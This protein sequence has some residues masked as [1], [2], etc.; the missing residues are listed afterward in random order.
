[1]NTRILFSLAPLLLLSQALLG[2]SFRT[3]FYARDYDTQEFSYATLDSASYYAEISETPD[4]TGWYPA[5]FYF[6]RRIADT[7]LLHGYGHFL[8]VRGKQ[9]QGPWTAY[10]DGT[11][12]VEEVGH[13]E[14]GK[15][16]GRWEFY[17]RRG[18]LA[19]VKHYQQGVLE[20]LFERYYY[21]A[22]GEG[23]LYDVGNYH[24]GQKQGEWR[25]YHPNGQQSAREVYEQDSLVSWEFWDPDG[26][27]RDSKSLAFREPQF[28][29]GDKALRAY[30]R[31]N[32]H[33]PRA[34]KRMGV[35]GRVYVAFTV[36]SDGTIGEVFFP[37][38]SIDILEDEAYR[39]IKSMPKWQPAI[40]NNR[41]VDSPMIQVVNFRLN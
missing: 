14:A 10:R 19:E 40:K 18:Q 20:G 2:Q 22:E 6:V 12:Q 15:A 28:P 29:G 7:V 34:A 32:L 3:N 17:D 24:Q 39:L 8:R 4:S 1:M 26:T 25:H 33:Y 16:H 11:D 35:Q 36:L 31:E 27:P 38:E 5:T 41:L 23:L 30:L 21:P 9:L 13:Y 37:L